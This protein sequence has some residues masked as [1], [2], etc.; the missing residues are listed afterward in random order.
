M[1]RGV[2]PRRKRTSEP[3]PV[4]PEKAICT[5]KL[6]PLGGVTIERGT[7]LPIDD[8]RVKAFPDYFLA[9]RAIREEDF[10]G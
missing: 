5:Q 10:S 9:V 6:I 7:V 4:K 1:R 3:A 2:L 8:D